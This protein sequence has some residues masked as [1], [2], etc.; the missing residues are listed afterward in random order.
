MHL[1]QLQESNEMVSKCLRVIRHPEAK[2]Y[3]PRPA[4]ADLKS[5]YA[6]KAFQHAVGMTVFNHY[7]KVQQ[8]EVLSHSLLFPWLFELKTL[9]NLHSGDRPPHCHSPK[10]LKK[11]SPLFHLY[12]PHSFS[13]PVIGSKWKINPLQAKEVGTRGWQE[14]EHVPPLIR[15]ITLSDAKENK[16]KASSKLWLWLSVRR[17][18]SM[19]S[20]SLQTLS[21][22]QHVVKPPPNHLTL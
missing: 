17:R 3:T 4:A 16:N 12:P 14:G 22:S 8:R 1:L 15:I 10:R 5:K 9:V 18:V 6:I 21:I 19:Y 13:K 20:A 7:Y 11:K 2:C